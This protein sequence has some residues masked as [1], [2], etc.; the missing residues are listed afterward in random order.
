MVGDHMTLSVRD[1]YVERSGHPV[2]SGVGFALPQGSWCGLIGVNGAGKT[3]L[4]NALCGRLEIAAGEV[5]LDGRILA[6]ARDRALAVG[7]SVP[8]DA[9]PTAPTVERLIS[10]VAKAHGR[11]PAERMQGLWQALALDEIATHRIGVLSAGQKQRLGL[12]LAFVGQPHVVLLD[13]PFNALDPLIAY[14]LRSALKAWVDGGRILITAMHDLTAVAL[15][16]THG[17]LLSKGQLVETFGPDQLSIAR[18]DPAGFEARVLERWRQ[19]E[20]I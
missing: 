16:C 12:Y 6:R 11:D 5:A 10:E 1:L 8:S 2:V 18:Q 9:L 20:R 15:H 17:L 4:L 7:V 19:A 14:D 13:E 3:T